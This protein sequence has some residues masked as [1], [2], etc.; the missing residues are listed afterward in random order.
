MY[1]AGII[2]SKEESQNVLSSKSKKKK[3]DVNTIMNHSFRID[4]VQD[5][6]YYIDSFEELTSSINEIRKNINI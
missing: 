3:F 2:S 5:T 4:V 1:G 6:Y